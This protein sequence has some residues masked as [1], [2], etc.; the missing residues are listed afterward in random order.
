[1]SFT[2][3]FNTVGW[4][5]QSLF[6]LLK[7]RFESFFLWTNE[8]YTFLQGQSWK[9]YR[10]TL[11]GRITIHRS[12]RRTEKL[13]CKCLKLYRFLY[14]S[15]LHV[16]VRILYVYRSLWFSLKFHTTCPHSSFWWEQNFDAGCSRFEALIALLVCGWVCAICSA[17]HSAYNYCD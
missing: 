7:R 13:L 12:L 9:T 2:E 14:S 10:D 5:N 4:S 16:V 17:K 6:G 3:L 1:M 15:C 8:G 11:R